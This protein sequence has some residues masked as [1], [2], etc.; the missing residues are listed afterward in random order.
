MVRGIGG[1]RR[2]RRVSGVRPAS[3]GAARPPDGLVYGDERFRR[4]YLPDGRP[5]R[6]FPKRD[7]G[8]GRP[9]LNLLLG[10]RR[11]GENIALA[12][13]KHGYTMAEI[14]AALGC[15]VSTVSRR[16]RDFEGRDA[17]LQD[18]TP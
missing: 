12:Y 11:D 10:E 6:E 13:R 9:D 18:L 3:P 2:C 7:W 16:L 8:D 5:G 4:R 15:H 17:R 14:A 1:G